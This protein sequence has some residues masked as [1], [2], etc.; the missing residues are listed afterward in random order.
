[1]LKKAYL[2]ITNICNAHC[3]FCPGTKREKRM[4]TREEFA[5]LASRLRSHTDYLYF[6]LMGEPL[7]H[8][9]IA[10]FLE[11]AGEMGFRVI[12]TTNGMLL[13]KCG[14]AI[15]GKK[16]LH[17][18]NISL[19][20]FEGGN[21]R[22]RLEEYLNSCAEFAKRCAEHGTIV[23][24]RLWNLDGEDTVGAH[25]ENAF[26]K[27]F[28]TS[29]HGD[30]QENTRGVRLADKVFLGYGEKF[31]WPDMQGEDYGECGFCYG[32]RDQVGVLC[33]GT[34]VPCCLD[35]E[36]DI[37]LGNLFDETLDE[38]LSSPAAHEIFDGFSQR[39]KVHQL[40]KKCGYARRF[41]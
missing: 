1:M 17:K 4:L 10:D 30:W 8:P 28:L 13:G 9:L 24:Y 26:I 20:S 16:A 38:I 35:H 12:I 3:N 22:G 27:D 14:D 23:S 39:R 21:A 25:D 31:I 34:V 41:S 29:F 11:I 36:G 33:D 5:L 18:V 19:H 40:C 37:P 32:L 2:E 6:H 7:V 15:I